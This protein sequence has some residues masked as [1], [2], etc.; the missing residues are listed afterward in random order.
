MYTYYLFARLDPSAPACA[1]AKV[2]NP[3]RPDDFI[4]ARRVQ[5]TDGK[6]WGRFSGY[7]CFTTAAESDFDDV[8]VLPTL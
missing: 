5:A 3:L 4:P 6:P 8:P 1:R 2:W 7:Y